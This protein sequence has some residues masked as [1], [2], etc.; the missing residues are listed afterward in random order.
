MYVL[1]LLYS[2]AAAFQGFERE[3]VVICVSACVPLS[4]EKII[5]ITIRALRTQP[6]RRARI[7]DEEGKRSDEM[8]CSADLYDF[9]FLLSG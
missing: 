6:A 8:V 3:C 9:I 5:V 4:S 1:A 7:D 2:R